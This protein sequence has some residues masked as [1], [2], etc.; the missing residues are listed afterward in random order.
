M[1]MD[2]LK[3][4]LPGKNVLLK[5]KGRREQKYAQIIQMALASCLTNVPLSGFMGRDKLTF[6]HIT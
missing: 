5:L 4:F 6:L 1:K 3:L 2:P